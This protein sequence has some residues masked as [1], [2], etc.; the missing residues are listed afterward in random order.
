[1]VAEASQTA[2]A[3]IT[4]TQAASQELARTAAHLQQL[5]SQF[6]FWV[7]PAARRTGH[8]SVCGSRRLVRSS[9]PPWPSKPPTPL[10]STTVDPGSGTD[11]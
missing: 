11:S 9:A 10:L 7:E 8:G 2:A 6:R 3:S 4:E 5:V 1:G